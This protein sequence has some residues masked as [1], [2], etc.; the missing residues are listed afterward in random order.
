MILPTTLRGVSL[1]HDPRWNKGTGF[2]QKERDA[3][4]LE[5]LLPP[6]VLTM[7][8]QLHRVRHNFD[9]KTSDI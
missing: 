1:I 7:E 2:T 9:A 6:R 8:E 4:G 3:L 5:G